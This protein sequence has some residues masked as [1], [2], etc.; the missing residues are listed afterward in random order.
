MYRLYRKMTIN[1]HPKMYRLY[2]KMTINGHPKM[3]RLYR[4]MTINGHPKMYRLYRKM[5]INGH[6]KMV[7]FLY[8]LYIFV[9]IQHGC[10]TNMVYAMDPNNS[11]IKRLWCMI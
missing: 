11:V 2:R 8:N 1:G 3:Y 6:P 10:L 5:T 7:I 4:K 9:W